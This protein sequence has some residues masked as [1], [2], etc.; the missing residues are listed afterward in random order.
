[1]PGVYQGTYVNTE[2]TKIE[3]LIQ[4]IKNNYSH[5]TIWVDVSRDISLKQIMYQPDGDTRT[6]TYSNV[7]YNAHPDAG[8][9]T[10]KVASGTQVQRR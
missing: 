7:R 2:H 6:V 3:D 8:L 5:V 10:L 1:M 9:F 4:N